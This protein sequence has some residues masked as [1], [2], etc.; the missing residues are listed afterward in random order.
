MLE[1]LFIQV[2]E[3]LIS[4]QDQTRVKEWMKPMS[5]EVIRAQVGRFAAAVQLVGASVCVFGR[6]PAVSAAPWSDATQWIVS[7]S[8]GSH[9]KRQ[10][11]VVTVGVAF[12]CKPVKVKEQNANS[13][14][15]SFQLAHRPPKGANRNPS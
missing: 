3:L 12:G 4:L 13:K 6:S 11:S 8:S 9:E 5:S 14:G 10:R 15:I 1:D 7:L 2:P